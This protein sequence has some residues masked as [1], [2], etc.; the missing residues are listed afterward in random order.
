MSLRARKKLEDIEKRERGKKKEEWLKR[1]NDY[2][3]EKRKS[4]ET[5]IFLITHPLA[6]SRHFSKKEKERML[7]VYRY[8]I[9][10]AMSNENAIV[11]MQNVPQEL[12]EEVKRLRFRD[13]FFT[14]D[15]IKEG[16][17][18]V[19]KNA[20]LI[21]RGEYMDICA[22]TEAGFIAAKFGLKPENV[23]FE[24][25]EAYVADDVRHY[26]IHLNSKQA[27]NNFLKGFLLGKRRMSKKELERLKS[28]WEKI[29]DIEHG[30]H[31]KR[32]WL[33]H[34]KARRKRNV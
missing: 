7:E 8:D 30:L 10:R 33:A 25:D 32:L 6:H 34:E 11:V 13:K 19:G 27:F 28:N 23:K 22:S 3:A 1:W 18:A 5:E 2:K 15:E 14:L 26:A 21:V 29:F 12:R 24:I 17:V 9:E 31:K 16:K 4:K 20:K